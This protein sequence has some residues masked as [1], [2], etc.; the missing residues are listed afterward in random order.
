MIV[1]WISEND[2]YMKQGEGITKIIDSAYHKA[3]DFLVCMQ[4]F[5]EILWKN[6]K[7]DFQILVHEK[8]R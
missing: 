1:L 2:I 7:I 3:T 8:L 5:L 4:E 6:N